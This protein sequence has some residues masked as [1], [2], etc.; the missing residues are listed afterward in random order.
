MQGDERPESEKPKR[1]SGA[2]GGSEA[3]PTEQ[4]A[5]RDAPKPHDGTTEI[6][7]GLPVSPEE[8]QRLKRAAERPQTD[9]D[10]GGEDEDDQPPRR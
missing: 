4:G 1:G 9:P 8:F 2:A 6:P 3:R 7:Q 10:P 5:A